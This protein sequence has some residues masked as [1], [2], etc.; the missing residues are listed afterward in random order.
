MI[1]GGK[2]TSKSIQEIHKTQPMMTIARTYNSIE[3]VKK[4]E[5]KKPKK[6]EG[7]MLGSMSKSHKSKSKNHSKS[8]LKSGKKG[9][10]DAKS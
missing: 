2:A 9:S 8:S 1:T 10:G 4:P 6:A 3:E 7:S 5:V